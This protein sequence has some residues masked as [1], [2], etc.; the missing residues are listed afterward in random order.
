MFWCH[1]RRCSCLLNIIVSVLTVFQNVQNGVTSLGM[2]LVRHLHVVYSCR[3]FSIPR[4]VSKSFSKVGTV[5]RGM[6]F[7][8]SNHMSANTKSI[9]W[10]SV[11]AG[12]GSDANNAYFLVINASVVTLDFWA[13]CVI[14]EQIIYAGLRGANVWRSLLQN[15]SHFST[16]L[17]TPCQTAALSR[18]I[19][20]EIVY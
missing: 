2:Y 8:I 6:R 5:F 14:W 10:V 1:Y 17:F 4:I 12:E 7:R 20:I 9:C 3:V 18:I 13:P 16:P 11:S 15:S 19:E